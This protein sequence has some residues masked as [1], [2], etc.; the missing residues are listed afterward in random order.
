MALSQSLGIRA[1]VEPSV[2]RSSKRKLTQD[3]EDAIEDAEDG[4]GGGI[5][6]RTGPSGGGGGGGGGAGAGTL[7]GGGIGGA[8]KMLGTVA[9]GGVVATGM[10]KAMESASGR[11]SGVSSIFGSMSKLFLKPFGDKLA[12][13]LLPFAEDG[14][15]IMKNFNDVVE[16]DGL[17]VGVAWL[18]K[19]SVKKLAEGIAGAFES[20]LLGG[21]ANLG[22]WLV[23]NL[24]L[25]ITGTALLAAIFGGLSLTTGGLLAFLFAGL[26]FTVGSIL[27]HIFPNITIDEGRILGFIFAGLT[28]TAMGLLGV[29]FGFTMTP[30]LVLGAA[31]AG[32]VV[33]G[34]AI[35]D[36][37]FPQ[38]DKSELLEDLIASPGTQEATEG[39]PGGG[40]SGDDD[41]ILDFI[42]GNYG[43]VPLASGGIATGPTNA[44]I[45]E[46]S[47]SEA[48]VPLS[49]LESMLDRERQAGMQQ[50][51]SGGEQSERVV[52][53][54]ERIERLLSR[55]ETDITLQTER[56][57]LGNATSD[58]RLF[59]RDKT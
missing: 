12:E 33:L 31:F 35:I 38:I 53:V 57:R 55:S 47:E 1:K 18:A 26:S 37:V 32:A 9:L 46:G 6:D 7:S 16:D 44:L 2:D 56:R 29:V 4:V 40:D 24:T 8:A 13:A 10:L 11:L 34:A 28:I 59:K 49:R 17:A 48:V 36:Y 14:L 41:S 3:V 39:D 22:D 27:S 45:G 42:F 23:S 50:S 30:A 20:T 21:E 5:M 52:R 15:E 19:T 58:E 54:L 43:S 25:G 51:Q